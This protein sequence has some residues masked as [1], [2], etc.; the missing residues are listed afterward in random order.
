MKDLIKG[1]SGY[2]CLEWLTPPFRGVLNRDQL[3]FNTAHAKVRNTVER[4]FGVLKRRFYSLAT[5]LRVR[6]M[7]LAAKLIV[8]AFMLHNICIQT[9]DYGDDFLDIPDPNAFQDD[10]ESDPHDDRSPG[11]QRRQSL[12]E[13]LL[14]A[15]HR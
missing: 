14:V 3:R 13:E 11:Q 2:P 6:N 5:M 8:C 7:Q 15:R 9:G 4:S 1:D 12:L 10:W